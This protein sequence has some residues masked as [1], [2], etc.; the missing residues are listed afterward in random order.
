MIL[1]QLG[2]GAFKGSDVEYHDLCHYSCSLPQG[3]RRRFGGDF[4]SSVGLV[5]A[6]KDPSY[7]ATWLLKG[8]ETA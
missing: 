4:T 3:R 6:V 1:L 2:M 7:C 5:I 8:K